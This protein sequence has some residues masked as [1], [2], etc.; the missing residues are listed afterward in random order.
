MWNCQ[1]NAYCKNALM[2]TEIEMQYTDRSANN[3]ALPCIFGPR[4]EQE[5]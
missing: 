5:K 2:G 3:R 4:N 1:I